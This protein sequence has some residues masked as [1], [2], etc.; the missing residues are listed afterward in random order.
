MTKTQKTESLVYQQTPPPSV[1]SQQQ[2]VKETVYHQM[3]PAP[4]LPAVREQTVYSVDQPPNSMAISDQIDTTTQV[5]WTQQPVSI[6]QQ[7]VL[8]YS[9]S[10]QYDTKDAVYAH[11]SFILRAD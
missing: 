4:S 7:D 11:V 8:L 10:L 6:S 2:V 5:S 1:P 9:Q 3:A